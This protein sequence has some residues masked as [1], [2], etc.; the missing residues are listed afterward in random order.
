MA[1]GVDGDHVGEDDVGVDVLRVLAVVL[2]VE[3]G[4]DVP[5]EAVIAGEEPAD[6]GIGEVDTVV[7]EVEDGAMAA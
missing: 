1:S 6:K 3:S 5:P 2:G 4:R 7:F